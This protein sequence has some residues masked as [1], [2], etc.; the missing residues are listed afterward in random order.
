[1]KGFATPG[2]VALTLAASTGTA[3]AADSAYIEFLWQPAPRNALA[4]GEAFGFVMEP[5]Q[6]H[7]VCVEAE[8]AVT[9]PSKLRIDVIDASGADVAAYG[10][11]S[12]LG[13]KKCYPAM[14]PPSAT[15][16]EW[17][18]QVTVADG[19]LDIGRAHV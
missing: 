8:D 9:G 11:G 3:F 14:V 6:H 5:A 1:M 16:A 12:F 13:A 17:H 10:D 4:R 19:L 2:L 15:P 7:V 18:F